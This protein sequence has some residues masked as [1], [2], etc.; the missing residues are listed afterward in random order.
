M[1]LTVLADPQ[2]ARWLV[3]QDRDW[4]DLVTRGPLG[5][6][7]YC[8]VLFIP[9]PV[10][11]GMKES[12]VASA[13]GPSETEQLV[14]A[15]RVLAGHTATP[16]ECYFLVWGGWGSSPT[17]A[18]YSAAPVHVVHQPSGVIDLAGVR[19]QRLSALDDPRA[20]TAGFRFGAL[21]FGQPI[22]Q[23]ERIVDGR[24][25]IDFPT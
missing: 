11:P 4:W 19:E 1:A 12:D 23:S 20:S 25:W 7:D 6:A 17:T 24:H 9:D 5:F 14:V 3:T 2:A 8:R 15:V 22:F 21:P 13:P 16:G 18:P 10:R